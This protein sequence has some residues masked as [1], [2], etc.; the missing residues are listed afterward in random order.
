[1]RLFHQIPDFELEDQDGEKVTRD[2]LAGKY[3]VLYFYPKANTSGC[4][5]EAQDF[6]YRNDELKKLGAAVVGVSPD[7]PAALTRFI[8]SKELG[9]PL[10]SDPGK[11]FAELAGAIN[12]K[13]G[14]L[15]S[16]FLVDRQGVLRWHWKK[17]RSMV[18]WSRFWTSCR[19]CTTRRMAERR[20]RLWKRLSR[21][22][23]LVPRN[24]PWVRPR[25]HHPPPTR[26][27]R[28]RKRCMLSDR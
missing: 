12:D 25:G 11:A 1:M 19:T 5:R 8:A 27:I 24:D 3:L 18:T 23:R 20:L 28:S 15:R 2:Q 26:S 16:T 17:V 10:L 13:G 4:T 14:I 21:I 6:T 9:I 22:T 7:K